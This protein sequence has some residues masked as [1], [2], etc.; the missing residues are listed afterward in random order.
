VK[1]SQQANAIRNKAKRSETKRNK[2][3]YAYCITTKKQS[4]TITN[5]NRKN[6]GD[7]Y[8]AFL[9][10]TLVVFCSCCLSH[11]RSC[12][13]MP[14]CLSMHVHAACPCCISMLRVACPRICP[15]CLSVHV[16]AAC[17]CLI[18]VLHVYAECS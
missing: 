14:P 10:M 16:H 7:H 18:Y 11:V 13:C 1:R 6:K 17:S 3:K 12:P 4:K 5:F 9:S 8:S 15:C 2:T